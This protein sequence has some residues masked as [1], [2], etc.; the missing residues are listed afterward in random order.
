VSGGSFG[1]L[2]DVPPDQ[3]L[4]RMD[5]LQQMLDVLDSEFPGSAAARDTR[6]LIEELQAFQQ[7]WYG[8]RPTYLREQVWQAVEWW[9][10]GD[11]SRD[12][13]ETRIR[14]YGDPGYRPLPGMMVHCPG[15]GA[16][17]G[18]EVDNDGFWHWA[19]HPLFGD[20]RRDR[21]PASG[22]PHWDKGKEPR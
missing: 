15:C 9:K 10:S 20:L 19:A 6:A 17:V 8:A 14:D 3:V 4:T 7:R 11:Y 12:Q 1:Y 13:V 22:E 18:V 2:C 5:T 21:C 16:H